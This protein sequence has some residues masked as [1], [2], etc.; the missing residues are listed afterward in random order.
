MRLFTAA[1]AH[2]SSSFSPI[3]TSLQNFRDGLLHRPSRGELVAERL[4][5][6]ECTLTE[7]GRRRGHDVIEGMAAA[8]TPSGPLGK[9]DFEALRDEIVNDLRKAMPVDAIALF[10]HGAQL[11]QGYDDCEG[12]V[13]TALRAVAGPDIPIGV[14][15]D[16]HGNITE[17]MMHNA[18]LI[19]AC[20]EY[21]HTDFSERADELL[22]VLE[23]TVAGKVSPVAAFCK[24]PMIG[25][26]HTTRQPMRGLVDRIS[27]LEHKP[28][29][30]SISIAHGF[31][32]ADTPHTGAAVIVVTDKDE[33]LAQRLSREIARELFDMRAAIAAPRTSIE[34][35]L[36]AAVAANDGLT[37]VADTADN[38]GGGAASDSTHLLR[39]LLRRKVDQ[40]AVGMIWDPI[41]VRFAF[42]AG[43]G[44][45][46]SMRIGGKVSALSG[47]PIDAHVTVTAC[48]PALGQTA[49]GSRHTLGP[50]AALRIDGID[51]V[52]AS[53]REQVHS[54]EC[55]TELGIDVASRKLL[56][57]KSAQHFYAQ[58]GPLARRVIYA[59]APGTT[60]VDFSTFRYARLPRPI[61]P[62]DPS[63]SFDP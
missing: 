42:A 1:L 31:P 55:F 3:P 38:A 32:W 45:Q 36:T 25:I 53:E 56:V 30:L 58:F 51:V 61:W 20:K 15:I 60:S 16:L 33:S 17:A 34:E 9:S 40:A 8:A 24:L 46:L 5:T 2:E 54:P 52:V 35:A 62:L 39:E 44:A 28:G 7:K 63:V 12:E 59:V 48:N 41:A 14:E 18:T 11:A 13:L 19:V 10:M 4:T 27:D 23:A 50:A 57:V 21:P 47:A 26:F 6:I 29:V 43:A 49:F 37:I 22:D